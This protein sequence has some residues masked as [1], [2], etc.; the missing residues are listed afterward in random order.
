MK[1][2][3]VSIVVLF[4]F[5]LSF[6]QSKKD[7]LLTVDGN[8]VYVS[9]FKR[10]YNKNLDLVKDES[11]K[12][13]DGYLDLFIDYKLKVAAAYDL[14]LNEEKTYLTEFNKYRDQLSRNYIFDD[15]V[16]TE[17]TKEA[18]ERGLEEI[19]VS[20]ILIRVGYEDKPQDTLKAYNKMKVL[21][22]KAKAGEDFEAL[23]KK[24]SEEPNANKTGGNLGYFSV[25]GMVYPFE[26]MAYNTKK[27]EISEIVRTQFGY[28]IIKVNDK[29]K[30]DGQISASHI[31]ITD[32]GKDQ[33]FD[34]EERINELLA[35]LKQG[36]SFES[37]ATQYSDDKNSGKK[38]GKLKVFRRGDLRAIEFEDAVYG[39]QKPGD[40]AGPIK[41]DFGWHIIRLEQKFPVPTYED[42]FPKLEE[43]VKGGIRSKIV[44]TALSNKIKEKYTFKNGTSHRPFFDTYVTEDFTKR[45]WKY[46]TIPA[47]HDEVLFTIGNRDVRFNDFAQFLVERQKGSSTFKLKDNIVND[48]YGEFEVVQLKKY[49]RDNLELE[50]EE[51]AGTIDEYRSGLLIFDVMN[52]NIWKKAKTDSIGLQGFYETRKDN[53]MGKDQIQGDIISSTSNDIAKRVKELL[54]QEKTSEEIKEML[55]ADDKVNVLVST[56]KFEEGQ[57]ELPENFEMKKGVSKVYEKNDGFIV[58]DVEYLVPARE[59]SLKDVKGRVLSDY[60]NHLETKWMEGLRQKY[61]VE[62]NKKALKKVK[63]AF[64]S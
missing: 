7:I 29:R 12:S 44:T 34:P 2:Y 37:L 30:R 6:S 22:D 28:H 56:G 32:K 55:N 14:K 4:A 49:F 18:Y 5:S 62:I 61:N 39:L 27:G 8:P 11:Q 43:R 52:K 59:K 46:D 64:R 20:H 1:K 63:K 54:G 21:F 23:A 33:A 10:V 38:G 31:M 3:L 53:Y 48:Y 9:E 50:N 40:I 42:E 51:Y 58:V 57:R 15:K 16:S 26:T 19:N 41:T 13:V 47:S 17:L 35:L 36:E 45:L 24:S 60:Q 25:F